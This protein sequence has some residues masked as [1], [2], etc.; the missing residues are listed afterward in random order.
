MTVAAQIAPTLAARQA[1]ADA[2]AAERVERDAFI[3]AQFAVLCAHF[4][5]LLRTAL[6]IDARVAVTVT[7]VTYNVQGRSFATLTVDTWAV[8]ASFNGAPQTVTFTPRL[9]F[10]ELDQFGVIECALDFSYAPA[11]SRGDRT[12]QV[13]L[14]H[15]IQ[16]RGKTLA[17]LLL[18]SATSARNLGADDLEDAF[19]V[20]WLRP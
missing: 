3:V 17:N 19:V 14:K 4:D 11:R 2:R 8:R 10:R 18:P 13:L 1:R 6:G 20:W 15:G 5:E 12:A 9:D 16:L 7:P